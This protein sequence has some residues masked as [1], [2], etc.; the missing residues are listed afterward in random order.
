MP[1]RPAAR[2]RIADAVLEEINDICDYGTLY[3]T[4]ANPF[5]CIT[6][7]ASR[8]LI[9]NSITCDSC[10]NPSRL[11]KYTQGIDG[12]RWNCPNCNLT[13]SLRHG[14]FFSRSHLSLRKLVL[15]MY[16]WSKR[17]PSRIIVEEIGIHRESVVDWRNFIR[18]LM[19]KWKDETAPQLGG[20]E[21]NLEPLVVEIDESAFGRFGLIW[22]WFAVCILF[23]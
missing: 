22:Y 11:S 18:D 8:G 15:I 19:V 6:W 21:D 3:A 17:Y 20:F 2:T 5:E 10:G 14:S 7:L 1:G 9:A 23:F 12:Y 16:M 13:K 4:L